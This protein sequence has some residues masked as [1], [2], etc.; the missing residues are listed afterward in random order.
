MVVALLMLRRATVNSDG[1]RVFGTYCGRIVSG[2][3]GL[4]PSEL[5]S[6]ALQLPDGSS[7]CL[8]E[9][10]AAMILGGL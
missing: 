9:I 1:C 8:A 6:L 7:S 5:F 2:C 10:P 3:R 4:Q